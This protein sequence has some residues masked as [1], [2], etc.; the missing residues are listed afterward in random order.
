M[1]TYIDNNFPSVLFMILKYIM[2]KKFNQTN[3]TFKTI[4]KKTK[5][6]N[7]YHW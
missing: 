5:M 4:E 7:I 3:L 2:E 6:L 1:K